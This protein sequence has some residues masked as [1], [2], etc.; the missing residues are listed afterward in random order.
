MKDPG[1]RARFYELVLREGSPANVL[2]YIDGALLV[3]LWPDIV[4]P[5]TSAPHGHPSWKTVR[6]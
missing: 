4:L 5:K 6:R 1:W 2:T 3:D